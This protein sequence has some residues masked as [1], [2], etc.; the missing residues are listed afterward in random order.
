[1]HAGPLQFSIVIPTQDRPGP[2]ANCLE[3]CARLDFPRDQYE[4]IVVDDGS[5]PPVEPLAAGYANRMNLTI[6][7][8]PGRG[9]GLARNA[10]A[11]RARGR[12]LAF[13]DDD[14]APAPGWL[15]ALA[16]C[17]QAAPEAAIGGKVINRLDHNPY[18]VAS[19]I[20][21]EVIC[22]Y[23]DTRPEAARFFT[24]NNFVVP[25]DKFRG[26][27]GFYSHYAEDRDLCD[28]WLSQGYSLA[29]AP[30][31]VVYHAH[32]MTLRGFWRTHALYGRGAF[33]YHVARARRNRGAFRFSPLSAFLLLRYPL[34]QR[35]G[36][37]AAPLAALLALSKLAN[38]WGF[39]AEAA[40][41]RDS[42]T[43]QAE[44]ATEEGS[45]A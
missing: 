36:W 8:Q 44:R 19:Q 14:C 38:V 6:V 39:C 1:M 26:L 12:Y 18:S 31:A 41:S 11:A 32:A 35:W 30:E 33:H 25:A 34:L 2:L 17:A 10:G 7:T 20:I 40:A 15:R 5:Q 43:R 23:W 9:P 24:S 45:Q 28:R 4:V 3:A 27:G 13:T 37:R 16:E 42:R 22:G 21:V 29:Y